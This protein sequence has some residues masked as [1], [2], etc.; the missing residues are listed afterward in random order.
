MGRHERTPALGADSAIT[1]PS[2]L[3]EWRV[4]QRIADRLARD[5]PVIDRERFR[6]MAADEL[7]VDRAVVSAPICAI[8]RR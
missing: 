2:W 6:E 8:D 4:I 1:R 5:C 7:R 3:H